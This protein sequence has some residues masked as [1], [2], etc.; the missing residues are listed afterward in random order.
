MDRADG[1]PS[2]VLVLS[3][4][5]WLFVGAALVPARTVAAPRKPI[6]SAD[7]AVAMGVDVA[8]SGFAADSTLTPPL[9]LKWR[10]TF[11][12]YVSFPLM[13]E[14]KDLATAGR[15]K[16][17]Q[18][19][20]TYQYALDA[21]TGQTPWRR[22]I[23]GILHW[24]GAAYDSGKI[25]VLNDDRLLSAFDAATGSTLWR[26]SPESADATYPP[27]AAG[28]IVYVNGVYAIAEETGRTVWEGYDGGSGFSSP[29]LSDSAV[30]SG[31]LGPDVVAWDRFTGAVLWRYEESAGG[32]SF[33]P[34]YYGGRLYFLD[35]STDPNG[36]VFDAVTGD[37]LQRVEYWGWTPAFAGNVGVFYGKDQLVARD[38]SSGSALWRFQGDRNLSS[39]PV[40]AN[41]Y[42][43]VGSTLG[44]LYAVDLATGRQV[45]R[46][47]VGVPIPGSDEEWPIDPNPMIAAG[48]GLL[49]VP[50]GTGEDADQLVAFGD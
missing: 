32:G 20:G 13:A 18:P 39:N 9:V 23:P 27:T 42:V 8:H 48:G 29:A 22:T 40:V 35:S 34:V 26:V 50:A 5:A 43:Y 1:V 14:G 38:L 33:S 17:F 6:A 4:T 2:K 44:N 31:Q 28:G 37:L 11:P 46:T 21:A 24:S 30:F 25:F 7:Q 15:S 49:V 47:N 3:V 12:G 19:Y 10:R 41:G 36:Y 45:W 16:G